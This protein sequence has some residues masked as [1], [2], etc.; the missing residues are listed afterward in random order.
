MKN[1]DSTSIELYFNS[2]FKS[3]SWLIDRP[4]IA[5]GL[6]RLHVYYLELMRFVIFLWRMTPRDRWI[7][8]CLHWHA[9]HV[10][11]NTLI[12]VLGI[13]R[14]RVCCGH[15][16]FYNISTRCGCSSELGLMLG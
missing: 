10:V 3:L 2:L 12:S 14:I 9:D 15:V 8:M 13:R 6:S 4:D 16:V 1:E 5:G 11:P 7:V